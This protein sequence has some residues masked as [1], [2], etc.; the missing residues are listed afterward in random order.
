MRE[1]IEI[2]HI[3]RCYHSTEIQVRHP[4]ASRPSETVSQCK[5]QWLYHR[6]PV[7]SLASPFTERG[8]TT[9]AY[10]CRVT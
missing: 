5:G 6:P 1:L 9:G 4:H 10:F 8:G 3:I 7:C 2:R